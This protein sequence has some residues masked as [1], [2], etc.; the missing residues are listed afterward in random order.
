MEGDKSSNQKMFEF[1]ANVFEQSQKVKNTILSEKEIQDLL[2]IV[3][4]RTI[5][6]HQKM[7]PQFIREN[8]LP[9]VDNENKSDPSR[10][11]TI[12]DIK[13]WQNLDTF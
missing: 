8:I 13:E 2:H 6:R 3:D 1:I 7:S 9:L 12:D 11:I 10:P 4:L 5:L